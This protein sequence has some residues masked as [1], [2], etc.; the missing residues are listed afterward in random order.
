MS[1]NWAGTYEYS[2]PRVVTATTVDGI[3]AIVS[4][5]GRVHA[6][7]TRH[8]FTDLPDTTGTLVDVTGLPADV[9]LDAE[10]RTVT[11][12]A[13]TRYGEL[14]L[15]LDER[16]W[17]LRNMGSLPHINVGGAIATG[18]HGS[19][20]GNGVLSTGV[21]ALRYVGADGGVHDV[22]RGDADFEAL[23]VGLGAYGITV[24]VTLDV[25]PAFRVR[26][27]LYSGVSW[28]AALADWS[29]VTG[30]A[31]SVSVFSRWEEPSVGFVWAKTRLDADDDP[32]PLALLDGRLAGP[33]ESPLGDHDNTTEIGGVPGSWMLRLPHFRLDRDPSFGDEIQSEYFVPRASAADALR[34]VRALGD[35]IRPALIVTELRTAAADG[36]WLS[37]AY[38][39]D[40]VIIHFTWHNRPEPV[41]DAVALVEAALEPFA[42][43]PHWGKYHRF[44]AERIADVTPRL[45]DAR[46]VFERLDPAGVFSNAHLERLGVRTPR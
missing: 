14:A 45:A 10:D 30:A 25:V 1:R 42:A 39:R 44:E 26:Q 23:V 21:R 22:R 38:E 19:G 31:Y 33:G 24:S 17:A 34:A 15:W 11:V 8:S 2:A 27:D 40:S 32:V 7:G 16:G 20:D 37:P 3:R 43:R 46:A 4:E 29:A 6:L 5:G 41:A 35:S 36:L 13:G 18:T 9:S 28:D 12:G